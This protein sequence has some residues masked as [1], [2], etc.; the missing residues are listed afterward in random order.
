MVDEKEE[1]RVI[2]EGSAY[3]SNKI[4][5]VFTGQMVR[6]TFAEQAGPDELPVFRAAEGLTPLDAIAFSKTLANSLKPIEEAVAAQQ[7][8]AA[9][10]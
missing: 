2:W 4:Y 10:K 3:L 1:A 6:I 5:V 7:Q 9:E 8:Q